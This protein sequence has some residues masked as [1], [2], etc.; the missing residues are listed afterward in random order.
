MDLIGKER[1]RLLQRSARVWALGFGLVSLACVL[2]PEAV[3]TSVLVL[4]LPLFA[5]LLVAVFVLGFSR[6]LLW[7][8]L[9]LVAGLGILLVAGSAPPTETGSTAI[10]EKSY[11]VSSCP[12]LL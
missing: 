2:L 4:I 1:D 8:G 6:S 7:V 10:A 5:L 11:V 3:P 12:T 9:A